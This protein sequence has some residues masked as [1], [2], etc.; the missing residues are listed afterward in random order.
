MYKV[1]N[2][3][4]ELKNVKQHWEEMISPKGI[5]MITPKYFDVVDVKNPYMKGQIGNVKTQL[6]RQQWNNL[7]AVFEN[8]QKRRSHSFAKNHRWSTPFRRYGFLCQSIF[9]VDSRR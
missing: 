1:W 3:I 5:L 8:W 6:A 2:E 9:R 4:A 7:Y